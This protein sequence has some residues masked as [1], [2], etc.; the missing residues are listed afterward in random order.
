M[1]GVHAGG[2]EEIPALAERIGEQRHDELAL[3]HEQREVVRD[4]VD[5]RD[6]D[7]REDEL[8]HERTAAP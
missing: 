8:R 6:R 5:E 1:F 4:G 3:D 2:A 7:E